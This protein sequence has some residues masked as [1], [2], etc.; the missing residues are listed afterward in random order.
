MSDSDGLEALWEAL[1][2]EDP[3]R[4]VA[5]WIELEADEQTAIWLHL[6]KMTTED[7]WADVQRDSAQAAINAI[8]AEGKGPM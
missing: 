2:S 6:H 7:G 5:M 4:I 3:P 8:N 1:L